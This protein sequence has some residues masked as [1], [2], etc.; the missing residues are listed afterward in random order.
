ME[1]SQPTTIYICDKCKHPIIPDNTNT[2]TFMERTDEADGSHRYN[3]VILHLHDNCQ[4]AIY[5][6]LHSI[7]NPF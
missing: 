1:A 7:S 4:A 3:R 2:F 5:Q 6:K